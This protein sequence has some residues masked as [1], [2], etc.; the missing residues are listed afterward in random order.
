MS[1]NSDYYKE[2]LQISYEND[3]TI[4]GIIRFSGLSEFFSHFITDRVKEIRLKRSKTFFNELQQ[5]NVVL[6]EETIKSEDFL[7]KFFVS[8][9]AAINTRQREK[10]RMFARL[11]NSSLED[12]PINPVDT[13]EDYVKILDDLSFREIRALILLESFYNT[14]KSDN[15]NKLQW[16]QKFWEDYKNELTVKLNIPEQLISDFM[17]RLARTGL[18]RKLDEN[19]FA[20]KEAEGILT[21]TFDGLKKYALDKDSEY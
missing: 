3:K 10:I 13:F 1:K 5:R 18:F 19:I 20:D 11:L 17:D 2:A 9:K 16:T 4:R 7:H 14:P 21:P 15:E 6:K 8:Y 12:T